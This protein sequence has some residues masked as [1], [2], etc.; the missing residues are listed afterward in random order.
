M[1]LI[2][3]L[4]LLL[5]LMIMQMF[6]STILRIVYKIK[7]SNLLDSIS[8]KDELLEMKTR[9]LKN[10]I[11]LAYMRKG[12]KVRIDDSKGEGES[13]LIL[14]EIQYVQIKKY[15]FYN[16]LEVEEAKKLVKHMQDNSIYRGTII[17]LGDFKGNTKRFCFINVIKCIN[18]DE[19][20]SMCKEV[21]NATDNIALGRGVK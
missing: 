9:D 7:I 4:F 13:C 20:L 8:F 14:D 18:G 21:Q 19:L 16:L 3:Y 17:S 10:V 5:I 11:A 6:I 12:F 2:I 1:I 15:P